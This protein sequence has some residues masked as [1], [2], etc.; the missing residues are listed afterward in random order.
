MFS[1]VHV[2]RQRFYLI[3][4]LSVVAV[5][6]YFILFFP[7]SFDSFFSVGDSAVLL[8]CKPQCSAC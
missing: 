5:E 8:A 2:T 3:N 7:P 1:F 6:N 4:K